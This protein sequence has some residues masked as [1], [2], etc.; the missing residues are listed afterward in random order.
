M[1]TL[2]LVFNVVIFVY[3]IADYIHKKTTNNHIALL[4]EQNRLLKK[5][6]GK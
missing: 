5:K 6:L 1:E 2:D 3:L 4:K